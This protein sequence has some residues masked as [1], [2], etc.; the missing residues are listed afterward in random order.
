[1]A[2]KSRQ[3]ASRASK[4]VL[5]EY[6]AGEPRS[7]GGAKVLHESLRDDKDSIGEG[8]WKRCV[9]DPEGRNEQKRAR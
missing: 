3:E 4:E 9:P 6:N 1:M 8:A 7:R 5:Q 2:A